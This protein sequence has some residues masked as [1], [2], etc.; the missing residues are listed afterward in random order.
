MFPERDTAGNAFNVGSECTTRQCQKGLGTK[1]ALRWIT[2]RHEVRDYSFSEL[3]SLSNR[4]ANVLRGLGIQPGEVVFT[5]L[6]KCPEQFLVFLGALKAECI[7]GTLFSSFGSEALFDRLSDSRARV[8]V[9]TQR[10]LAKLKPVLPR[11]S[12]L[13]F[14]LVVDAPERAS[15]GILALEALMAAAEDDFATPHTSPGTP[16]VLH[17]TS[18]STGKPKGVLHCHGAL[19]HQSRTAVQVLGLRADDLFWCTADQGWVTGTAYGICGPWSLGVTQLHYGGGF[20]AREWAA[21][22]EREKVSVWYTAPTA[23]RMLQR[24]DDTLYT[25]LSLP[26]LRSIFSV[27]EALNPEVIAWGRRVLQRD[28]HDTWFQTE[29]GGIMIA[30]R[31][32]LEIRPGSMGKPCDGIVVGILGRDGTELP[33]GEEGHLCLRT[34][35]ESMFIGYLNHDDAYRSKF[36]GG[37]YFTG[38]MA[39]RDADDYVWFLGRDDDVINSS[40]HLISPFEIESC[41]LELPEVHDSAVTGA[42]DP[43]LGEKVVA[44]VHIRDGKQLDAA[45]EAKMKA[46]VLRNLGSTAVPSEVIAIAS[47]P[48][49]RS[50]KIM[51]RYLKANYLG[52]DAGDLSTLDDD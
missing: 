39:R 32:G 38:D 15:E 24:E 43:L 51:R 27:G 34:G 18:G 2:A 48:R 31:P 1:V 8:V 45:L 37:W 5:F 11:L 52:K 46:W 23:L 33:A 16:S 4:F 20:S 17:Y 36:K 3:D 10:H 42:P 19:I 14:V 40:G 26:A 41:L 47:V 44:F 13:R 29:T 9:T 21:L 35:W 7:I 12:A 28:I 22:L 25:A 6:P 30:N 49:N 50:G